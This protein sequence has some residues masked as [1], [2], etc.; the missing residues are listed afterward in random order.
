MSS[1]QLA[2]S[3]AL[4]PPPGLAKDMKFV[5]LF[6]VI[7]GALEC[8]SIIGALIGVPLIIAG[9]RIREAGDAYLAMAQGDASALQRSYAGQATFFK[10]QKIL[11]IVGLIVCGLCF[12]AW[13]AI[14]IFAVAMGNRSKF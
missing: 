13:I 11:I 5:G 10:I 8:L 14:I 6:A 7:G 4:A 9:L 12:L 1:P 2:P 3:G